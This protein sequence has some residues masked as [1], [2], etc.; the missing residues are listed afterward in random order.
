MDSNP[1]PW[2]LKYDALPS[3]LAGLRCKLYYLNYYIYTCTCYTN[4][5]I[6][7]ILRLMKHVAERIMSSKFSVLC[8]ILEYSYIVQIATHKSYVC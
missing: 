6:G 3:E 2:D 1:Q 7:I 5:Y 4:E 8:Y